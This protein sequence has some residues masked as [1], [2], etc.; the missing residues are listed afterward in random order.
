MKRISKLFPAVDRDDLSAADMLATLL[1][2]ARDDEK[3][4][5]QLE[6]ILQ[7]P[8]AQRE[9]VVNTGLHEMAIRGESAEARAAF[10]VLATEDGARIAMQMLQRS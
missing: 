1:L 6:L 9:S 4:R 5:R 3:F 7:L 10:A 2:A 8:A